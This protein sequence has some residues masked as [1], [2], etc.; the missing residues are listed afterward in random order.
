[1]VAGAEHLHFACTACGD[2]CRRHRVALTH[3]DLVRIKRIV[4]EPA[5]RLV[6]WLSPDELEPD[7]DAASFV[8]LPAG[9]R[10]MVLAHAGG[11]CRFLAS[12]NRCG[13]YP[14]R[15][16][17]C[18]MYPFVLERDQRR[19]VR[20]SLFGPEGCGGRGTAMDF[21]KLA[22]ADAQRWAEVEEYRAMVGRW[23]RLA[24]HRRRFGHRAGTAQQFLAR[25]TS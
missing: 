12:D 18:A 22:S 15:P 3:R 14:A 9:P 20:L 10:L 4:A 24:N 19:V 2:C 25:I 7:A 11:A 8:T 5:E 6:D 1:M 17:D 21:G 23:N 13:V 16:R